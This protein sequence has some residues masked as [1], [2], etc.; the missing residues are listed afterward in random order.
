M[1]DNSTAVAEKAY[2]GPAA[3]QARKTSNASK[4][5]A[6]IGRKL[7]HWDGSLGPGYYEAIKANEAPMP[8]KF[9]VIGAGKITLDDESVVWI[10]RPYVSRSPDSDGMI[11]GPRYPWSGPGADWTMCSVH[12]LYRDQEQWGEDN[13]VGVVQVQWC[14]YQ[15]ELQPVL[16]KEFQRSHIRQLFP[17]CH[18]WLKLTGVH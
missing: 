5:L 13:I 6:E 17:A 10:G 7:S 18:R 9:E 16:L 2:I 4:W 8:S 15:G 3:Q 1:L 14:E 11:F 12:P